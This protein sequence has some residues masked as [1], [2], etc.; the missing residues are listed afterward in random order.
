MKNT[1]KLFVT[2]FLLTVLLS[3]SKVNGQTIPPRFVMTVKNIATTNPA[4]VKGQYI[5]I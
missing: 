1:F 4:N 3:Q 5:T 2:L